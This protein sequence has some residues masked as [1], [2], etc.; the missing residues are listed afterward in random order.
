MSKKK[1]RKKTQST[2]RPAPRKAKSRAGHAKHPK[3]V[4]RHPAR[5][6]NEPHSVALLRAMR[7]RREAQQATHHEPSSVRAPI[8]HAHKGVRP[9]HKLA[10]SKSHQGEPVV[11]EKSFENMLAFRRFQNHAR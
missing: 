2:K 8:H 5:G 1:P 11:T 10:H 3:A 4:K 9:R 6:S 7:L